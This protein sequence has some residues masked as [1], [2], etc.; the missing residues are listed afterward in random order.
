MHLR[1]TLPSTLAMTLMCSC[2]A[3]GQHTSDAPDTAPI[4]DARPV[5]PDAGVDASAD[6]LLADALPP[7]AVVADAPIVA[8][9]AG[10]DAAS[11]DAGVDAAM[12]D[13]MPDA[14]LA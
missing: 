4:T 8:I 6:A 3:G 11:P 5:S 2:H 10:L 7:D 14:D 13:A 9:D 12:I 1:L